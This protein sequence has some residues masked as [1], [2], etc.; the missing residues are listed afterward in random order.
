MSARRV[1]WNGAKHQEAVDLLKGKGRMIV[2]PTKVGYIIMVSDFTGL[3]RKFA[4]QRALNK[5]S[6]VLC[7]SIGQL[8]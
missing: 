8:A 6:V 2:T 7:S 5:P 4:K 3:Q 1:E